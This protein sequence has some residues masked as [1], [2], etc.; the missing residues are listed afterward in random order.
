MRKLIAALLI[1]LSLSACTSHVVVKVDRNHNGD[2][3]TTVTVDKTF[4]K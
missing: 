3:L 2:C 1:T 4:L